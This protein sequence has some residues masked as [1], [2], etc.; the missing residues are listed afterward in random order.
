MAK[1]MVT[2]GR[3]VLG[4][5]VV[6][7]L[8]ADGHEVTVLTR[9]PDAQLPGSARWIAGDLASGG[10]LDAAVRDAEV[11]VHLATSPFRSARVDV[12]GTRALVE[13][14]TRRGGGPHLVYA[15]IAG[16]D[17]I[18]WPYYKRKRQAEVL[19]ARSGLPFTIQR[20][21]QFH[22][23]VLMAMASAARAPVLPVPAGTC[24]QPVDAADVA[25]RL[26]EIVRIGPAGGL[27]ADLGGPQVLDAAELARDVVA[28]IGVR[29]PVRLIWIPGQVGAGFRAGHHLAAGTPRGARTWRAYLEDRCRAETGVL[30]L[31]YTGRR[32]PIRRR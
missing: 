27:A 16:V 26:A 29:R 15:S 10:G 19:V 11:V 9:R 3:G 5:A 4:H 1:V 28:A 25:Q 22:D 8:Q 6:P 24:C 32:V 23:L 30:P 21:T 20:A 12:G 18:P 14:I 7:L 31:P 13:A 17:Q 2:G